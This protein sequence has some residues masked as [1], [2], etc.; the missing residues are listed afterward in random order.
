M[1]VN[2]PG[3]VTNLVESN[4]CGFVVP[5]EDATRFADAL[6]HAADTRAT[7]TAMRP[8]SRSLAREFDRTLLADQFVDWLE[9]ASQR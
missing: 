2:Y 8:A 9:G 3:W 1:L 5:P 6:E 4:A 7:L